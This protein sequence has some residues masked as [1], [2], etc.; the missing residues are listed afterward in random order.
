MTCLHKQRKNILETEKFFLAECLE[1]KLIFLEQKNDANCK[2]DIYENY[3][4]AENG[5]K[6]GGMS[7]RAVKFF[8]FLRAVKIFILNPKNKK[9]LDI[10]SGR[11]WTLYFLKKYFRYKKTVGTQISVNAYEFS[12]EKLKLEIFD[13]DLLDLN[14]DNNKFD[15]ITLWHVLEHIADPEIYIRKINDLLENRGILLI[16]VPNYNSW[17]R[18]I[19][20]KHWLAMD[21]KHHRVFFTPDSLKTLLKKYNFR[22]KKTGTF[23]L[24]YSAFTS[25]QSLLNFIT[26]TDNYFF[27]WLQRGGINCKVIFHGLLFVFLFPI[28]LFFNC[29]MY[30][31]K[32]GEV[33][34]IIAKKD[35]K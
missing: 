13:R 19:F 25:T 26:G 33:I 35:V 23:S 20:S 32:S 6:F 21:P 10:G 2:T 5:Q 22:I 8:R 7:E 9:I 4:K 11:G 24:E 28:G 34:N 17:S 18:K 3:Y 12:K 31:S 30:F 14:F 27:K 1:C 16:E 29:L 15:I